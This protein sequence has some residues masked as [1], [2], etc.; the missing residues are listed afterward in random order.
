MQQTSSQRDGH[1]VGPIIRLKLVDDI[2]D[3]KTHRR[4]R[5]SKVTRNLFIPQTVADKSKNIQFTG[6]KLLMSEMFRQSGRNV[7]GNTFAATVHLTNDIEQFILLD[8]LEHIR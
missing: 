3:V 7:G 8:T 6:R 1:R 4:L 5:D 2:L